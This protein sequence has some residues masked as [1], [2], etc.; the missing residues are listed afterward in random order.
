MRAS[1]SSG[2]SMGATCVPPRHHEQLAR[3]A[4]ASA[5]ALARNDG[6]NVSRSPG[7]DEHRHVDVRQEVARGV[8][9]RGA[10][11]PEE[12]REVDVGHVREVR[13]HVLGVDALGVDLAGLE[14]DLERELRRQAAPDGAHHVGRLQ[15]QVEQLR[16]DELEH[17]DPVERAGDV[18]EAPA[19]E[20]EPAHSF[21][22][23]P[24]RLERDLAAHRVPEEH[25]GRVADVTSDAAE[26]LRRAAAMS[27]RSRIRRRPRSARGPGS[28]SGRAGTSGARSSQR[29]FQMKPSQRIAVAEDGVHVARRRAPPSAC[30]RRGACRPVPARTTNVHRRPIGSA[31]R[32]SGRDVCQPALLVLAALDVVHAREL[33]DLE[34][35]DLPRALHDPGERAVEPGRL[36]LDF[37]EHRLG[38]VQALLALVG[39]R[40]W[41]VADID[42]L[43]LVAK[44]NLLRV[45]ERHA[46]NVRGSD[47]ACLHRAR[48]LSA[49]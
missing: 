11:H 29:Y 25:A 42:S 9:A 34:P 43:S 40:A 19:E 36:L 46:R 48:R 38:E 27:M 24:V 31:A 17:R 2:C 13:Q 8:L 28:A 47:R 5:I 37:L 4:C 23:L 49:A 16:Q 3:A 32:C 10:Q 44:G 45:V 21:G 7:D 30:G 20:D 14:R 6:V 22:P 1:T 33:L 12:H 15:R 26:V 39:L 41:Q 35:R 18:A